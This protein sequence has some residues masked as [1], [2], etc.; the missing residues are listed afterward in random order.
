MPG[1]ESLT[2]YLPA[3]EATMVILLNSDANPGYNLQFGEAISKVITPGDVI[4]FGATS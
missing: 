1:F 4:P 3:K 2:V